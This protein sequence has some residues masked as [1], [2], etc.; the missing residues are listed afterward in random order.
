MGWRIPSV[1]GQLERTTWYPCPDLE[2]ERSSCGNVEILVPSWS[3]QTHG[4]LELSE[5]GQSKASHQQV[6]GVHGV[7][8]HVH[9]KGRKWVSQPHLS[10]EGASPLQAGPPAAPEQCQAC[11]D[12]KRP[13][14]WRP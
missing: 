7:G 1:K 13:L 6:V 3:P 9:R 14:I 8:V 10:T 2:V 5:L 12:P 11:M 4:D